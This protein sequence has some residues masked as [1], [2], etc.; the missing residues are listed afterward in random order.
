[1][2]LPEFDR[3]LLTR[4]ASETGA[5]ICEFC[6]GH[7]YKLRAM[8]RH[9]VSCPHVSEPMQKMAVSDAQARRVRRPRKAKQKNFGVWET[10][11]PYRSSAL[12]APPFYP[13]DN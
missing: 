5:F 3:Y 11:R 12:N 9:L 13:E 7:Y 8:R 1:M 6:G 10:N 2:I 4:R